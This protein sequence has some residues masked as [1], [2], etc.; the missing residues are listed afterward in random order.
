M[1]SLIAVP[2]APQSPA[3]ALVSADGWYPDICC[4][5]MRDA[6]RLG[7]IVTHPRLVEAIRSGLLTVTGELR[8]WRKA[9]DL[10]GFQSLAD[11]AP[12]EIIDGETRLELLF[13]RAVRFYAGAELAELHRDSTATNEA[14]TRAD[15]DL[16]TAADYRRMATWAIRDILGTTRTAVELI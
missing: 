3:N 11:V 16:K 4:N 8:D 14:L 6:L 13:T 1:S 2:P 7:D 9:Q 5:A 15:A 12:D 10:A